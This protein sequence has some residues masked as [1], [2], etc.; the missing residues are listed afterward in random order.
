MQIITY[1]TR[2]LIFNAQPQELEEIDRVTSYLTNE[3]L[4]GG[5]PQRYN[6]VD[7]DFAW[8]G[9]THFLDREGEASNFPSGLRDIV[10]Q[11]LRQ[12][13]IPHEVWDYRVP[14]DARI[15]KHPKI[16]L[17]DH[18]KDCHTQ[19]VSQ[20]DCVARMPPRSGKTRTL[21]EVVRSL[22]LPA[23]WIAPTSSIVTQTVKEAQKWIGDDAVHVQRATWKEQG[24]RLLSVCTASGMLQL[25]PEFFA[26][27]HMIVTDEGHHFVANKAWGRH[28]LANTPHIFHRKAM[29]GTFFRSNGDDLALLAHIGRV[30]YSIESKELLDK[31]FL[32]PTYTV[33]IPIE[34]PR[35]K[36]SRREFMAEGGHGHLGIATHGHRNDVVSAVAGH[37]RGL[38]RTVLILVATKQQGYQIKQRLDCIFPP[39][40][41]K[42]FEPVEFVSTDRPKHVIQKVYASF[43]NH[44]A[45]KVLIGTS[46]V[47]EGVDLPPADALI[48]ASGGKAAVTYVQALYRVC[49]AHPGK[50][51]GVIVDFI[52][53]H[54]KGLLEHS[55]QRWQVASSDPVFQMSHLD[56]L[57]DFPAWATNTMVKV[58]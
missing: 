43:T 23:L 3:A 13:Q 46:M 29:T 44:E 30:G 57:D 51:Y 25:P 45:V 24:E 42:D 52:D 36:S 19:M 15:P 37:L 4:M 2:T 40:S 58:D 8:D 50:F 6:F 31:G 56:G 26:S 10:I 27:K 21:I 33:F 18:Q 48:Y 28:L 12:L 14:P 20:G 34:G 17:W 7:R 41:S 5:S 54:H 9:W 11:R 38:N 16:E 35:V 49:T 32:V 1:N 53:K 55:R 47:G 22:A 39:D